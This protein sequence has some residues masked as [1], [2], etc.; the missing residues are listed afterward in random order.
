[1]GGLTRQQFARLAGVANS[2]EIDPVEYLRTFGPIGYKEI[3]SRKGFQVAL[4]ITWLRE[5][6]VQRYLR[7][8][9]LRNYYMRLA[10]FQGEGNQLIFALVVPNGG[11]YA[12]S[13]LQYRVLL[14]QSGI[15]PWTLY[16]LAMLPTVL[17]ILDRQIR[18]ERFV[19]ERPDIP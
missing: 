11:L 1:L 18:G 12:M 2:G 9:K 3:Q 6:P 19:L 7:L 4:A 15:R 5:T 13:S 16:E 14:A 17:T 10:Q 8:V